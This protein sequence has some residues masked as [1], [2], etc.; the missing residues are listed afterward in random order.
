MAIR[1]W[2]RVLNDAFVRI[3]NEKLREWRSELWVERLKLRYQFEHIEAR[4]VR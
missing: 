2:Q 4:Y 1:G 3:E